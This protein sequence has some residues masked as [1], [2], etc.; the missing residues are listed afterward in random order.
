MIISLRPFFLP[1]TAPLIA[2]RKGE[3]GKRKVT[4]SV[5]VP[6]RTRT[7]SL[8]VR[9][10]GPKPSIVSFWVRNDTITH[11]QSTAFSIGAI[12]WSLLRAGIVARQILRTRGDPPSPSR[13]VPLHSFLNSKVHT[14]EQLHIRPCRLSSRSHASKGSTG[15]QRGSNSQG[16]QP[17][18][19]TLPI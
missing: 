11:L 14:S 17:I 1:L 19:N 15:A 16:T 3:R 8:N 12:C 9:F 4:R 5:S 2:K 6:P 7:S 13:R 10:S 18:A